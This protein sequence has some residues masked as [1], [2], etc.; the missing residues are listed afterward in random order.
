M[1]PLAPLDRRLARALIRVA[2]KFR[3]RM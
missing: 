3:F 2:S 1:A